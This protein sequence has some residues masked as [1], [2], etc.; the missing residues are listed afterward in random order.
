MSFSIKINKDAKKLLEKL[1]NKER[2]KIIDKIRKFR[3]WLEGENINVDVKKLKGNWEGFYRLRFGGFRI[4]IK[5]DIEEKIIKIY[6]I[7]IRGDIYR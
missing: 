6:D 4:L 7:G 2:E 3:N 5:I 1:D